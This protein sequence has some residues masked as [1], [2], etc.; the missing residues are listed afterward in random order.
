MISAPNSNGRHKIGVAKVL[1]TISG[2]SCSCAILANFSI[3]KTFSAGF[4]I[5]SPIKSFVLSVNAL[6]MVSSSASG[7][8]NITSIPKRFKVTPKRLNVP[9]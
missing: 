4:A 8:T 6:D 2:T 7:S 3:S 9:P 5:V 1:S